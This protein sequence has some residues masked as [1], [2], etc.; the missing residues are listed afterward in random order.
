M[1]GATLKGNDKVTVKIEGGGPLGVLIIDANA[2]G[3]MSGYVT[4]PHVHFDLNEHGKLDVARAV[5]KNGFLSVVKD[6]GLK[7]MFTGQVPLVSGELGEDFTY[8]YVTSEQIPSSVGVG[9]LVNPDNSIL[10]AGGFMFQVMPEAE[11]EIIA[12]LEK[13]LETI[14]P[15]STMIHQWANSGRNIF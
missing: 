6:L 15:I 11:E 3:E 10:A 14:S 4:N 1:M 13:R 5:G 9:V 12:L 8:Y 2:V 7:E